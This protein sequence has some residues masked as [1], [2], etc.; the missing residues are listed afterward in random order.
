MIGEYLPLALQRRRVTRGST[1]YEGINGEKMKQLIACFLILLL[2]GSTFAQTYWEK[3][4]ALTADN[5]LPACLPAEIELT[6]DRL[7]E[8]QNRHVY[9]KAVV[10]T[11]AVQ[12]MKDAGIWSCSLEGK[13]L[14]DRH[15]EYVCH[16]LTDPCDMFWAYAVTDCFPILYAQPALKEGRSVAAWVDFEYVWRFEEWSK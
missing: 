6:P 11:D 9:G 14:F 2:S 7:P 15:G 13:L 10:K 5:C 8:I 4:Y 12:F 1:D 3:V 16:Q